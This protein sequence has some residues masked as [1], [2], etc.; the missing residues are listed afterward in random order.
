MGPQGTFSKS[1]VHGSLVVV[2]KDLRM[3]GKHPS[4]CVLSSA[5]GPRDSP[6]L[7]LISTGRLLVGRF[8]G[9]GNPAGQTVPWTSFPST[10]CLRPAE[11]ACNPGV[12]ARPAR[13]CPHHPPPAETPL[14]EVVRNEGAVNFGQPW[15]CLRELRLYLCRSFGIYSMLCFCQLYLFVCSVSSLI[16][17]LSPFV[18]FFFY[19]IV[20]YFFIYPP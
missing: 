8:P 5:F 2:W 14:W 6:C 13:P 16:P 20:L 15:C 1:R 4:L 9:I 17:F 18:R 3:E 7:A 11:K 19:F 12:N 10:F